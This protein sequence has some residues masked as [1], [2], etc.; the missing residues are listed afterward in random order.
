MQYTNPMDVEAWLVQLDELARSNKCE[1]PRFLKPFHFATIAHRL[2][3]RKVKAFGMPEKIAPYANTMRLW[4]ALGIEAPFHVSRQQAGRYHP[5]EVLRDI[6]TVQDTA[7]SLVSLLKPV[8]SDARTI[9][10][11][12]TMLRELVDNCYSHADVNDDV[13]GVICGQVWPAGSKA[14]IAIADTGIGIRQSLGLNPDLLERIKGTNCCELATEYGVTGKPGKGHSGYGLAVARKLLEQNNGSL[15]V[16]SGKEGFN[17]I[18]RRPV[19]YNSPK[20]WHGTLLVIEWD[21]DVPVNIG[22]VYESFPLPEGMTDD[23]FDF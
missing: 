21:L 1:A 8:C 6:N 15:I 17:L 10:A 5:I 18:N 12:H 20:E 16:R 14:Q 11:V 19:S 13:Y 2:R 23:D 7:D 9:D 3:Q 4:E 22:D